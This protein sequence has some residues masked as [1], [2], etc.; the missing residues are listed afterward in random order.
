MLM[1]LHA[2]CEQALLAL[3]AAEINS[4]LT[5]DLHKM[6]E[7]IDTELAALKQQ[8]DGTDSSR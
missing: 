7:R 5:D 8:L 1:I 6:V 2:T 3:A 4:V